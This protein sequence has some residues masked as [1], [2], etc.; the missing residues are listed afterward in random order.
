MGQKSL[1]GYTQGVAKESG[2]DLKTQNS[3]YGGNSSVSLKKLKTELPHDPVF[4]LLN[5][6]PG[7]L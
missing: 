1:A 7:K 2:Y 5:I 6:Y 4:P 3:N